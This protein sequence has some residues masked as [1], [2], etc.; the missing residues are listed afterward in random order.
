LNKG[1]TAGKISD[2]TR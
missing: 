1:T 2:N